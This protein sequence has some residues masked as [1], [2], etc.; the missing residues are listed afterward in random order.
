MDDGNYTVSFSRPNCFAVVTRAEFEKNKNYIVKN[1]LDG[2]VKD[3][4][5]LNAEKKPNVF[6]ERGM[7]G[8]FGRARMF[9]DAENPTVVKII[10][11]E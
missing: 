7:I 2:I 9:M 6:D 1:H 8:L 10:K 5:L 4:V 11:A 3:E